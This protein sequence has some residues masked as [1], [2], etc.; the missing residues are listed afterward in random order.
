MFGPILKLDGTKQKFVYIKMMFFRGIGY[1]ISDTGTFVIPSSS[2]TRVCKYK[3]R[4]PVPPAANV[5]CGRRQI[6]PRQAR[7]LLVD[8][9]NCKS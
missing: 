5:W 4:L 3:P 1:F 8:R 7:L 6:G 2:R 9:S